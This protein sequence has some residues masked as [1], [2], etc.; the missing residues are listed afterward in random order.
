MVLYVGKRDGTK[1]EFVPEK[2]VVSL[3]KTGAQPDYARAL[4][5]TLSEVPGMA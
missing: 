5:K 3:V 2:I 4:Q 1:E